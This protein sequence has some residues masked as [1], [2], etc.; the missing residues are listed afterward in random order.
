MVQPPRGCN[1]NPGTSEARINNILG[2]GWEIDH[3]TLDFMLQT[4]YIARQIGLGLVTGPQYK[5]LH[6]G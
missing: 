5:G 2:K 6:H 1:H 3:Q 4:Q